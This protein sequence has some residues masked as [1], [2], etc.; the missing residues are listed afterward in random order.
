M[1]TITI[2]IDDTVSGVSV[3]LKVDGAI[4]LL[5]LCRAAHFLVSEVGEEEPLSST[6]GAQLET[7]R[8][9]VDLLQELVGVP[10]APRQPVHGRA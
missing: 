9:V 2:E 6:G 10:S 7:I 5:D 1:R 4:S 8:R 3:D